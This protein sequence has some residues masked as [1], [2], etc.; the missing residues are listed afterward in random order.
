MARQ[1][2]PDDAGTD[3]HALRLGR[4]VSHLVSSDVE[5]VVPTTEPDTG[6]CDIS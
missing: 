4:N 5:G 1:A 6:G 2:V 3:D